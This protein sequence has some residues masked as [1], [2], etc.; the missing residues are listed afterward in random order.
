VGTNP[1]AYHD[2]GDQH[3]THVAGIIAARG[4]AATSVRGIAPGVTLRSYRVF[5]KPGEATTN[6][7]IADAVDQARQD[8]C[9]LINLSLKQSAGQVADDALRAAIEDA[10]NAGM[11]PI[12]AAGNDGRQPVAFPASDDLCIAVSAMGR[13]GTF[14]AD[15]VSAATNLRP[16]HGADQ[17]DF[18]ADFSNIGGDVDLTSPGVG[19]ISTVPGGKFAVMDGTSMACPVVTGVAARLLSKKSRIMAMAR[20]SHRADAIAQL[21]LSSAL[22]LGFGAVYEGRGKPG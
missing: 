6:F 14:P 16:P 11:L 5:G 4:N 3:G 13:I 10:R 12:A 20:D 22:P 17:D 9:D 7:D 19:T 2:N 8:K 15:S 21:L 18:I 1:A